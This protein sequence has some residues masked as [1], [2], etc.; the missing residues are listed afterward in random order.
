MKHLHEKKHK[1]EHKVKKYKDKIE[2]LEED[3]KK[4]KS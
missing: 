2:H 1:L 4:H 3:N